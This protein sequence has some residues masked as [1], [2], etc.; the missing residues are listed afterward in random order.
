MRVGVGMDELPNLV[1]NWELAKTE[2]VVS[3]GVV[4]EPGLHRKPGRPG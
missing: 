1:W 3:S 2:R 4:R